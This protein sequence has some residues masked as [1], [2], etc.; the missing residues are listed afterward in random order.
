MDQVNQPGEPLEPVSEE[1]PVIAVIGQGIMGAAVSLHLQGRGF[2][3]ISNLTDRSDASKGRATKAGVIDV[4]SLQTMATEAD[5]IFSILPSSQAKPFAEQMAPFLGWRKQTY[6]EL[7]AIAPSVSK[8]IGRVIQA[9][10]ATFIDAAITGPPPIKRAVNFYIS[11]PERES[12]GF[13]SSPQL[14][15][16][17][18]GDENGNASALKIC[19]SAS[20]KARVTT[21]LMALIAAKKLGIYDLYASA[22]KSSDPTAW[23]II[24]GTGPRMAAAAS[25]W[26]E[27]FDEVARMMEDVGLPA[28]LYHGVSEM[29]QHLEASPLGH[30]TKETLDPNRTI[31]EFVS[32]VADYPSSKQTSPK[33]N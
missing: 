1:K 32:I 15:L 20:T 22:Q 4:G 10:G 17:D 7:N 6:V 26:S 23:K 19:V 12:L 16:V 2:R 5:F 13:L 11:G 28:T 21:Y 29:F 18:C 27:E 24:E 31:D 8:Q 3:V 25:R 33:P 30:E 9:K 14:R